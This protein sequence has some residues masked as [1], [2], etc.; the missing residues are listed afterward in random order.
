MARTH[1][2]RM[3]KWCIIALG[4]ALKTAFLKVQC[5]DVRSAAWQVQPTHASRTLRGS[6]LQNSNACR[7][8]CSPDV[9]I[10]HVSL[11]FE[12]I[13]APFDEMKGDMYGGAPF[14]TTFTTV[15]Y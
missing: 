4:I 5:R 14:V 1:P 7:V 12:S 11:L 6:R 9:N 10:M 15:S 8:P 2:F 13:F 3:S